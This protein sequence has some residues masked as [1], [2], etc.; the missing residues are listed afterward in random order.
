MA[1]VL[2]VIAKHTWLSNWF[3][4]WWCR[5]A[6]SIRERKTSVIYFLSMHLNFQN[7]KSIFSKLENDIMYFV[8]NQYIMWLT[9]CWR[10]LISPPLPCVLHFQCILLLF[11]N[12]S[13]FPQHCTI[14]I[15]CMCCMCP[16]RLCTGFH[17]FR[18]IHHFL[19]V[20]WMCYNK[21]FHLF[22]TALY[23]SV[24]NDWRDDD[25]L[26]I[27]RSSLKNFIPVMCQYFFWMNCG[28]C[29]LKFLEP[30]MYPLDTYRQLNK[31][32]KK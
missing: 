4:L 18:A 5:L 22:R 6:Y 13:T 21:V 17:F 29:V 10:I 26:T 27:F 24:Q 16:H 3:V 23:L 1:N 32:R 25:I 11:A 2:Q 8:A 20:L 12:T 14:R 9:L 15:A 31:G 28:H 30:I 19:A 7:Q